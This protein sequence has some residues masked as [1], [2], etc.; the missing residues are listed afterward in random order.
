MSTE[1]ENYCTGTIRHCRHHPEPITEATHLCPHDAQLADMGSLPLYRVLFRSLL[2]T[3]GDNG[4]V[5]FE[6]D[7]FYS[8]GYWMLV[9]YSF[10]MVAF[11]W[12]VSGFFT[13]IHD[14]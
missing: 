5:A 9:T 3:S 6:F 4:F 12:W 1:N 2:P 14:C 8:V 13:N 11:H 7:S 10:G